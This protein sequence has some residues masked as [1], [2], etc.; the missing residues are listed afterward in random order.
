M[1][2]V[3]PISS[4]MGRVDTH[5]TSDVRRVL[6]AVAKLAETY[7]VA[8]VA[9]HHLRKAAGPAIHA[10]TGSQAFSDAV[11][12]VW[13]VG[14]DRDHP[15]RRLMLPSKNNLAEMEGAGMAYT[16]ELGR[17]V[18][19]Q[20]PVVLAADDMLND[21]H[22]A[23]A[24]DEAAGWLQLVLEAGPQLA[25]TVIRDARHDGISEKTLRRAK[26]SLEVVSEQLDRQWIWR[27]PGPPPERV[28]EG[29]P[30]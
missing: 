29:P 8:F 12:T 5:K 17:V 4:F 25:S 13:L 7:A 11:R 2:L 18:W 26:R 24:I 30:A 6:S 28:P 27:L 19:E 21:E 23:S 15:K 10:V 22:D 1:L 9:I 20:E 16:I 14:I 3:D